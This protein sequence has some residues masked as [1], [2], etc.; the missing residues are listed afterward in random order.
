MTF[1]RSVTA[2]ESDLL[3]TVAELKNGGEYEYKGLVRQQNMIK[4]FIR[5]KETKK[6]V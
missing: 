1:I 2:L 6:L 4:N 3:R 5:S